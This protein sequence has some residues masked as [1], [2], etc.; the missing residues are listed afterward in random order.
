MFLIT[1][2]LSN[3]GVNSGYRILILLG[4]KYS[5]T[6]CCT[7][8]KKIKERNEQ[9]G[10][11]LSVRNLLSFR[12]HW[13]VSPAFFRDSNHWLS[14]WCVLHDCPEQ[15]SPRHNHKRKTS[16]QTNYH[17][18]RIKTTI[19][20][21]NHQLICCCSGVTSLQRLLNLIETRQPA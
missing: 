11:F 6:S 9:S 14:V 18:E 4:V 2:P 20:C 8:K 10:P 3:F 1:V 12:E 5:G 7:K 13:Q 17:L 16:D 19:L 21:A 15:M